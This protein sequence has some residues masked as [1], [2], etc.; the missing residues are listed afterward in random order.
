V[1]ITILGPQRRPRLDAVVASLGLTGPFATVTAG[2]QER[3]PDDAELHALLGGEAVN[4]G[5]WHRW[6]DVLE[7]D[8]EYAAADRRRR[9]VLDEVQS[10]YLLGL[11]HAVQALLE[12]GRRPTRSPEALRAALE[13]AEWV[14]RKVDERHLQQ[15]RA[16]EDDF[17]AASRPHE[18]GLIAEHRGQ[19]AE[20]LARAQ[21]LVVTGG[22][23]GVLLE[24]LHLF[25][26]AADLPARQLPVI[27]WSAGA[28]ALTDRVVLFHDR[29]AH[30]PTVA[31]V[32]ATGL[33]LVRNIVPLPHA[34]RRLRIDDRDRMGVLARRFAP[35]HCLVLDDGARVDLDE[36]GGLPADAL[37]IGTDGAVQELGALASGTDGAVQELGATGIPAVPE[38]TEGGGAG[39]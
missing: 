1:T 5:L 8:T 23:V 3:E 26:V 16:L 18:R 33:G 30:G 24:V 6:Q 28:M 9:E 11:D 20:Q 34:R 17:Y 31:E 36:D 14:I 10:F 29:A 32:Y 25:N 35:A 2:W 12:L 27:A 13:E 19:V 15:V 38:G 39:E 21:A 37:V 22:H 4:L 7:R